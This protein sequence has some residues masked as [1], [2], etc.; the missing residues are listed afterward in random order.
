MSTKA[1]KFAQKR[2]TAGGTLKGITVNL[3]QHIIPVSTKN[4]RDELELALS[5]LKGVLDYWSDN[6]EQAKKEN[7]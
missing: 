5:H 7:L 3:K 4:E 2:N 1:Q 6:Y